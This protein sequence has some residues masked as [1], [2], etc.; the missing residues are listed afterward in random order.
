MSEACYA[1]NITLNHEGLT[2]YTGL[3]GRH[4]REFAN[5]TQQSVSNVCDGD[6]G[7]SGILANTVRL[8]ELA[9]EA[10]LKTIVK[11]RLDRAQHVSAR[12]TGDD[13]D[14]AINELIDIWKEPAT[15]A[16]SGWVGPARVAD[17]N[18]NDHGKIVVEWRSQHIPVALRRSRRHLTSPTMLEWNADVLV[19]LMEQAEKVHNRSE[20]HGWISQPSGLRLTSTTFKN[21]QR[22]YNGA[23]MLAEML[24][25]E[26]CAGIRIGCS[27]KHVSG[28]RNAS[29]CIVLA[30]LPGT[31]Q[32][33]ELELRADWGIDFSKM[34][35]KNWK[36]CAFMQLYCFPP[37][38]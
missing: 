31:Q 8:R 15:K 26:N 35:G 28:I 21:N 37:N 6:V 29:S 20:I 22:M 19:P 24:G 1:K 38:M 34:L 4:P 7:K 16:Q 13:C 12:P 11:D 10:T 18:P 14:Y 30:W 3:L 33:W 2:P 25:M 9:L 23:L 17:P 5:S 36:D 27:L 32:T